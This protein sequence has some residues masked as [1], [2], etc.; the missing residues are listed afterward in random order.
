MVDYDPLPSI[1]DTAKTVDK[2]APRVWDDTLITSLAFIRPGDEAA[3]DKAFEH[4]HRIVKRRFTISRVFAHYVN[5]GCHRLLRSARGPVPATCRCAVPAP[6]AP[7]AGGED[8][9]RS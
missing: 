2:D 6:G 4:A 5:P 1:T 9:Q 7:A 8:F 3:T